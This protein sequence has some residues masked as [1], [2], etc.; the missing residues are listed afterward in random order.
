MKLVDARKYR[1]EVKQLYITAFP[2]EERAPFSLLMHRVNNGRDSFYAVEDNGEFVGLVYTIRKG[3]LVYVF[4]LAVIEGKRG[5]GYGTRIL[6]CIRRLNPGCV[7]ALLIE[8]TEETGA[9]NYEQR[10]GR[11][12]F[13]QANGF[14][15]LNVRINEAGVRYELLGTDTT[16]TQ[17]DFLDLM[18]DYAGELLAKFLYRK[19][20]IEDANYVL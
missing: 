5:M 13:Y 8:D 20:I 11:L 6:R 3:S 9:D 2:K 15:Q 19:T 1:K 10:I 14:K 18:K 16:V 7:V 4:F 17:A 12:G